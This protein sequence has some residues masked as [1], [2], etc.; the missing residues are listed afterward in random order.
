M[1]FMITSTFVIFFVKLLASS[2]PHP[3]TL[4]W[5]SFW[6]TSGRFWKYIYIYGIYYIYVL[7]FY[8]TFFPADALTFYLTFSPASI[9]TYFL[10]YI[11]R[12]FLAFHLASILTFYLVSIPTVYLA[13]FQALIYSDILSGIFSRILSGILSGMSSGPGALHSILGWGFGVRGSPHGSDLFKIQS[14]RDGRRRRRRRRWRR[15]RKNVKVKK[16]WRGRWGRRVSK[17]LHLC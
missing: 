6:H 4:W 9:L 2:H 15:R 14:R 3:D 10:A 1:S 8:L 5:H 17:E 7:T 16:V 11:L 12:F 13:S